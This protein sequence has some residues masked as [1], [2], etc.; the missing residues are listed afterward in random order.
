MSLLLAF[1]ESGT[2]LTLNASGLAS[3]EAVG[4][5]LLRLGLI[6]SGLTS[7]EAA[8][9]SR[10]LLGLPAAGLTT[11]GQLGTPA[12]RTLL[13]AAALGSSEAAGAS[14]VRTELRGAGLASSEALGASLLRLAL[15]ASGV[16]SAEAIGAGELRFVLTL[17]A[18]GLVSAETLGAGRLATTIRGA[19]LISAEAPGAVKIA[20]VLTAAGMPSEAALGAA[21]L[22]LAI[23]ASGLASGEALG[24]GGLAFWITAAS[25]ATTGQLG[26]PQLGAVLR[27]AGLASAG[28]LGQSAIFTTQPQTPPLMLTQKQKELIDAADVKLDQAL[29]AG[30]LNPDL[31]V[32]APP[33][34]GYSRLTGAAPFNKEAVRSVFRLALVALVSLTEDYVE[35][36][37][38]QNGWTNYP[39]GNTLG[40]YKNTIGRVSFKGVIA[41][42]SGTV[43]FTLPAG[44]RPAIKHTL[45]TVGLMGGNLVPA[46]LVIET[47]GTILVSGTA[48]TFTWV[49]FDGLDMR[50]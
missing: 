5:A 35:A 42:E 16:T 33:L 43:C 3:G 8:G 2:P 45:S 39:G 38:L 31:T 14:L 46:I 4:I 12:L 19:G 47:N 37:P 9:A 1:Q 27:G 32:N 7:G 6:A 50:T 22:G 15:A 30:V 23:I 36:T 49:T 41:G 44:Y 21:R 18:A 24:S 20:T 40:Y 25:L 10:L 17:Q 28:A 48:G 11:T 26:T 34:I 29:E 13:P